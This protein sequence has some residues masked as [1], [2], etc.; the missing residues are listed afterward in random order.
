M[1]YTINTTS[2]N[3]L[4]TL[5]DGT[6]DTS[7]GLT[8]IGR[9]YTGYGL[10][11][12]DNFVRLL[13]NFADTVPPGQSIGYNPITGT[14]WFDTG[15]Q[16]LKVYDGVNYNTVSGRISAN[17]SP[18][19]KNIGDQWWDT[20]NQ[21]L[22]TWTG[23]EWYLI[24]PNFVPGQSRSGTYA[25]TVVDTSGNT[26]VVV[27]TYVGNSIVSISSLDSAFT[28][29]S[30][31]YIGTFST[32]DPGINLLSGSVL[33]GTA[34]N[35]Q[36]VGGLLPNLFARTDIVSTFATDINVAGNLVLSYG[37]ISFNNNAIN[38]K[39]TA[40]NGNISLAIYSRTNGVIN[41]INVNGATGLAYVNAD[42][43]DPNGIA[44]KN[45][46][47]NTFSNL[48]STIESQVSDLSSSVSSVRSDYLSNIAATSASLQSNINSLS[49]SLNLSIAT[50]TAQTASNVA[51]L[52]SE[53][54]S[55]A[56]ILNT[57]VYTD[58]PLLAPIASPTFTGAPKSTATLPTS[59]NTANLAT[60][61][62]VTSSV[63]TASSSL[64][65]QLAALQA[66]TIANTNSL[67]SS[68]A[69][70]IAILQN[71]L[72]SN[73]ASLN[74]VINT[75][76]PLLAPIA[77]PTFTGTPTSVN[78]PALT[79][80]LSTVSAGTFVINFNNAITTSVG[81]SITLF[82][83]G[84]GTTICS[85]TTKVSVSSK[86][87]VIVQFNSGTITPGSSIEVFIN[88]ILQPGVHITSFTPG[89]IFSGIGDQSTS[90]VNSNYVD[91]TANLLYGDYITRISNEASAR[92][93]AITTAVAPL[94]TIASPTFTGTPTAPTPPAG[95]STTK[96]ATTSFV[97]TATNSV[98]STAY[99]T[100]ANPTSGP[101]ISFGT[102][103]PP[104]GG[105]NGDIYLQYGS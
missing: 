78:L 68:L 17:S 41:A 56:A 16:L 59:D 104:T 4:L 54:A 100:P 21:Q 46:V 12:N 15:N 72:N 6:T 51:L 34:T 65:T 58:L 67:A 60:T 36:T 38:I 18:T 95:D 37:N 89:L 5:Q 103:A 98:L 91:A 96:I 97:T 42:P 76:L 29:S 73:A 13:E 52:S 83:S 99:T 7:T 94:A 11:Q 23:T 24:G 19:A 43:I 8:L 20:T 82:D 57:V 105:N 22:K 93:A 33:N 27:S 70:N 64:F 47:D 90:I 75:N 2:G 49:T 45:Y 87:R 32:I 25:D 31:P 85:L 14:L 30:S 80:Y 50:L 10:L 79:T 88:G 77:S 62:F 101:K 1:S 66:Q 102:G 74:T 61:A 28:P 53:I 39:N 40:L 35:S 69:S 26:H 71:E 44:T 9:N 81:D 55:N 48:D 3:I 84:S 92:S 63:G 86:T